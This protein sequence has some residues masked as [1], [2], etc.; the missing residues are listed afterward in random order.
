MDALAQDYNLFPGNRPVIMTYARALYDAGDAKKTVQILRPY[1]D[2]SA[3]VINPGLYQLL[4]NASNKIGN[5]VL[6]LR[7]MANVY[8][9]QA[10]YESSI[11]QLRLALREKN[12]TPVQQ[13]QIQQQMDAVTKEHK[14]AKKWGWSTAVLTRRFHKAIH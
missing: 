4:A 6:S 1:M 5:R 10:D 8:E 9:L 13:Q 12:L 2:P 7:A 14:Q 3:H 11:I